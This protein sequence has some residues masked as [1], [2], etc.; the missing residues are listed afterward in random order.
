MNYGQCGILLVIRGHGH[1]SNWKNDMPENARPKI[2][3]LQDNFSKR[4]GDREMEEGQQWLDELSLLP[5]YI[6]GAPPGSMKRDAAISAAERDELTARAFICA[7]RGLHLCCK[8]DCL[9]PHSI[10]TTLLE[11]W[12][13]ALSLRHCRRNPLSSPLQTRPSGGEYKARE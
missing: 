9:G 1:K 6:S 13:P 10:C 7:V 3:G 8:Q 12:R 11:D 2:A 5:G 4:E